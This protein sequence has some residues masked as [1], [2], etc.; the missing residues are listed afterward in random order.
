MESSSAGSVKT[1]IEKWK[2]YADAGLKIKAVKELYDSKRS[3]IGLAEAKH[4][5]EGYMWRTSGPYRELERVHAGRRERR[6]CF[7]ILL[8]TEDII[9]IERALGHTT[10]P[11]ELKGLLL[12]LFSGKV[13]ITR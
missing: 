1:D 8:N 10:N 13:K 9:L 5:V 7:S 3:T 2:K 12:E 4:I 6:E 11:T